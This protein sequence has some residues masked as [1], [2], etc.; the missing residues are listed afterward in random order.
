VYCVLVVMSE[1]QFSY[2]NSP[3]FDS[4]GRLGRTTKYSH[5]LSLLAVV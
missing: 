3:T 5:D 2:R 4:R 1:V